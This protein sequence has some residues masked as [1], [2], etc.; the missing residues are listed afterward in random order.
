MF[1][2]SVRGASCVRMMLPGWGSA[3]TTPTC[4]RRGGGLGGFGSHAPVGPYRA[5]RIYGGEDRDSRHHFDCHQRGH[6]M[7]EHYLVL[8]TLSHDCVM[9]ARHRFQSTTRRRRLGL[10]CKVLVAKRPP[11]G[12]GRSSGRGGRASVGFA[13]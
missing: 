1:S 7:P 6:F 10:D 13:I 2:T 5:E 3:W 11:G 8:P 12:R 4:R 9:I